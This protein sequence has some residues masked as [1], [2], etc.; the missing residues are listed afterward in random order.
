MS[1]PKPL[2]STAELFSALLKDMLVFVHKTGFLTLLYV[3][4]LLN[5]LAG[6]Y[7]QMK[8]LPGA[9]MAFCR[10]ERR[11]ILA[12]YSQIRAFFAKEGLR[13]GLAILMASFFS[14]FFSKSRFNHATAIAGLLIVFIMIPFW[15]SRSAALWEND[16]VSGVSLLSSAPAAGSERPVTFETTR[17]VHNAVPSVELNAYNI[18]SQAENSAPSV[19]SSSVSASTAS[20]ASAASSS[21]KSD[22]SSSKGTAKAKKKNSKYVSADAEKGLQSKPFSSSVHFSGD[23][24]SFPQ[25]VWYAW[26]RTRAVTGVSLRFKSGMSWSAYNW[27][28]AVKQTSE[29]RVVRDL[30]AVRANSV[31]VFSHS[32]NGGGHV[33]FIES[34]NRSDSGKPISVTIS[35]SHWN[36]I[37][38]HEITLSW[39]EFLSRSHGSLEGYIYVG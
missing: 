22:A 33:L 24:F 35:E 31:A 17:S 11:A 38:P 1:E 28:D 25:C 8:L 37:Y 15:T 20:T 13:G 23:P 26:G 2:N 3:K 27:L 5:T 36:T 21:N 16:A 19:V 10:K 4:R 14:R 7:T 6:T 32:S 29:V 12:K 34:V 18:S 39:S 30:N 9:L